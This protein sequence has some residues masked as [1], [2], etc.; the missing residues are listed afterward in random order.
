MYLFCDIDGVSYPFP[1]ATA[2]SP[3]R[4]RSTGCRS[5]ARTNWSASGSTRPTDACSRPSS[6]TPASNPCGARPGEPTQRPRSA[7]ASDSPAGPPSS[8]PPRPPTPATPAA[9]SGNVT[10][11]SATPAGLL[12]PAGKPRQ[13][14]PATGTAKM[15]SQ[16]P[17]EFPG[18][19][20][21]R[22]RM[23]PAL[24]ASDLARHQDS[25][26]GAKGTRTPD[27]L[28]AKQV[29]FQLSYSP[30]ACRPR[31]PKPVPAPAPRPRSRGTRLPSDLRRLRPP[32]RRSLRPRRHNRRVRRP[33]HHQPR[34]RQPA[35][36]RTRRTGGR[37]ART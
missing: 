2:R 7:H 14:A 31:L 6:P 4:T 24:R 23:E 27:P 26:S 18:G 30:K 17:P 3:A 35:L 21:S 16:F 28:L 37:T 9:T 8:C 20:A 25:M 22:T 5:P 19:V 32:R 11:L 10:T 15:I 33:R 36:A 29:L 13:P 34:R 12:A 1:P